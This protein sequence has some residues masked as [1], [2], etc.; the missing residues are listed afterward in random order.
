[1]GGAEREGLGRDVRVA[2]QQVGDLKK[3]EKR[4]KVERVTT[5]G[6]LKVCVYKYSDCAGDLWSQFKDSEDTPL[7]QIQMDR[8]HMHISRSLI[9][10]CRSF[11]FL[12]L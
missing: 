1:M 7:Y 4:E 10:M 9:D 12:L 5:N 2:K 11:V 6:P 8:P 3:E